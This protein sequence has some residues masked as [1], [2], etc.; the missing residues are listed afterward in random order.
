[1]DDVRV[2]KQSFLYTGRG[3]R[4]IGR[5]RKRWEAESNIAIFPVF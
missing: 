5:P 2:S 4:N 1:M 3:S